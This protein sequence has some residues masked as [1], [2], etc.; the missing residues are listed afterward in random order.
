MTDIVFLSPW[1]GRGEQTASVH[2]PLLV[3]TGVSHS[4]GIPTFEDNSVSCVQAGGNG[5]MFFTLTG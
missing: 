1:R 3:G 5:N 2:V 4:L